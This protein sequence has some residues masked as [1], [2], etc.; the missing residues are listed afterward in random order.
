MRGSFG[1][2]SDQ[3]TIEAA[4]IHIM[5]GKVGI[6]VLSDEEIELDSD[7]CEFLK[8]HIEKFTESDDVKKC[9]FEEDSFAGKILEHCRREN[10]AEVSRQLCGRLYK[11]MNANPDI[12]SGDVAA[13]LFR[14]E[15]IRYFGFLKMNYKTSYTHQTQA[16]DLGG[17][18]N[19]IV[20]Q[21]ALLPSK[22]QKLSEAFAVDLEKKEILLT[23]K[24]Y[25]ING[26]KKDYFSEMFLECHGPMSQKTKL[27]LVTRAVEQVNRKYF[28]DEDTERKMEVK[29]VFYQELEEEGQLQVERVT[30]KLF[31]ASPEMR[32]D[33]TEKMEKY[34]MTQSV[35]EPKSQQTL[36]KFQTQRLTTEE[37]IEITIPMEAY[38]NPEKVEFIT[39]GDGTISVLIKNIGHLQSK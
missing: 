7:L 1:M 38:G 12:P 37:G 2:R 39:N 36:K 20:L 14:K 34:Q 5:D 23:E 13:L 3:I 27:E 8:G 9:V 35:V 21:R 24:R 25:E 22:T 28:G 32:A 15:G 26:V 19:G 31:S 4:I 6:P 29:N 16:T 11:M 17:N 30:E 33:F 18:T 10:F